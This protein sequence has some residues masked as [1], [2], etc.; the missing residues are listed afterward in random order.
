MQ[1]NCNISRFILQSLFH[2]S[3]LR[4]N[5]TERLHDCKLGCYVEINERVILRDNGWRF[6]YLSITVKLFIA[7]LGVFILLHLMFV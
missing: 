7:I 4:I 6:F 3:E 2:E 5:T 1:E